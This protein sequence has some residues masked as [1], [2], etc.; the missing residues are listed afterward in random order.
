MDLTVK[1]ESFR[2]NVD[3]ISA[4]LWMM[5]TICFLGNI[6]GG[7]ISTLMSV[8]LP[9][10]VKELIGTIDKEQLNKVSAYINA[11]FFA[12]W[13]IGGLTW[14]MISDR[15]GRVRSLALA[16]GMFGLFTL[17][18]AFAPTWKL[19]I[20]FRFFTGFG[21]GGML[22]INTTLLSEDWPEK[23]RAIFMGILSV[24]FPIGIFSSG[25]VNYLVS[26]W[27][28][29]FNIGF[30]PL[31]I[32]IISF[33][34][35]KESEKWKTSRSLPGSKIINQKNHEHRIDLVNG[36]IIFGCMLIGLW[37]IFSWLPT[38][39]QS[40][41]QGGDGQHERGM[42]MMLL[43]AGGLSGGFVS[44]WIANALGTRKSM[45]VCFSGC[46]ILSF[47]LFK[48]NTVFSGITLIEIGLL[49]FMF[50]ISQGLLS[51]Y[52]PML[53]PVSVR[54]ASTGFCFNIGRFF[55]AAAVFFVGALVVTLGGYGNS[56]FTFSFV[57]LIGFIML[58]FS[59]NL[60]R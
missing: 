15:I 12:G 44:G 20:I 34:L 53:F 47:L 58:L 31:I 51:V 39:V 42:S 54:A 48:T 17:F 7:T 3:K 41:L 13:A 6:L 4:Y 35:L 28:Q 52:I 8:Y 57:F 23:T 56:L 55:T 36:S 16:V 29:G 27:R 2:I 49:S 50:G 45:L 24:G 33:W 10:V 11:L 5:F 19:V 38:W 30:F 59:K 9:E 25:T 40:I 26:S 1:T 37:A 46:F 18:T 60:T 22:V 21:I 32:G 14:G 43:G